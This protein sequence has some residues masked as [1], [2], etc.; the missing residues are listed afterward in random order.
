MHRNCV[1][2]IGLIYTRVVRNARKPNKEGMLDL[3]HFWDTPKLTS[4]KKGY[5]HAM[6]VAHLA[7]VL[8]SDD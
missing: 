4:Q 7:L 6:S 2:P 8:Y 3:F 5:Q 1:I